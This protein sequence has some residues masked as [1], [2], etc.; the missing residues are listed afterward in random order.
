MPCLYKTGCIRTE[1]L[2]RR[3]IQKDDKFKLLKGNTFSHSVQL[4]CGMHGMQLPAGQVVI[5]KEQ[6]VALGVRRYAVAGG[7]HG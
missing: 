2:G 1:C 6:Y 4:D 7:I 3:G 5:G